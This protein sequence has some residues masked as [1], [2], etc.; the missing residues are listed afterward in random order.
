MTSHNAERLN[1]VIAA[2][3][4]MEL[5]AIDFKRTIQDAAVHVRQNTIAEWAGLSKPRVS[6]IVNRT[7]RPRN[8]FSGASPTEVAQRYAAGEISAQQTVDELSR[9]T[10]NPMPA[11]DPFDETWQPGEGTWF[12]VETA[13][14]ARLITDEMFAAIR[15]NRKSIGSGR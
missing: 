4:R 5:A 7:P 1:Q 14:F 6:Q 12:D 10:Y 2:R 13:W 3:A 15:I 9:W 11:S 8:G